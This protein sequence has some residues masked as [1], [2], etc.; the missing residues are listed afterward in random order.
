MYFRKLESAFANVRL[1][2]RGKAQPSPLETHVTNLKA[3]ASARMVRVN[4]KANSIRREKRA[5]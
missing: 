3:A 4:E 2:F 1:I 5:K